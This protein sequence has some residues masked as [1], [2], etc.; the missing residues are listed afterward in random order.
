MDYTHYQRTEK[1]TWCRKKLSE[2]YR[3]TYDKSKVDCP[4][5]QKAVRIF[6]LT[7]KTR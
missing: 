6:K 3:F 7:Y 4:D 2:V 5:C 1:S